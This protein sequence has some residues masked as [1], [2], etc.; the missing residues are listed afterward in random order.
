MFFLRTAVMCNNSLLVCFD[1]EKL[2]KL[3]LSGNFLGF[4]VNLVGL[5]FLLYWPN[6]WFFQE[7]FWEITVPNWWTLF[8]TFFVIFISP[9]TFLSPTGKAVGDYENE[10]KEVDHH[11]LDHLSLK[12]KIKNSNLV[13]ELS[14]VL[15]SMRATIVLGKSDAAY[16]SSWIFLFSY[17]FY[18]VCGTVVTL[19]IGPLILELYDDQTQDDLVIINL[20]YKVFMLIGVLF[21]L[22]YS[23]S[24]PYLLNKTNNNN[25]NN[26][27]QHTSNQKKQQIE[28]YT[29]FFQT[30]IFLIQSAS[31]FIALIN[32]VEKKV[33]EYLC[34]SVG[35]MYSWNMSVSRG[36]FGGLVPV[37][38]KSEFM[39][40]YSSFTYL[41]IAGVGLF[42]LLLDYFQSPPEILF[43]IVFFWTIPSFFFL[44]YLIRF[45]RNR[46]D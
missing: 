42:D 21:G 32:G 38:K 9:L 46:N 20:W 39:G 36:L 19:Y 8:F 26:D 13:K 11:H 43:T 4:A 1:K 28:I 15:G 41:A 45:Q 40:W 5:S 6:K 24:L 2:T 37:E 35:F 34:Y 17:L 27:Q 3:S 7:T 12:E 30:F 23:Y 33:F 44:F 14:T 22:F 31:I 18:S 16:K 10:N 25:S 29:L